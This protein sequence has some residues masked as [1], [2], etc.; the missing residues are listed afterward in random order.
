M[1]IGKGQK[2]GSGWITCEEVE[3]A[4]KK[5]LG[6]GGELRAADESKPQKATA[7]DT[8]NVVSVADSMPVGQSEGADARR[9][10]LDD[11]RERTRR[12]ARRLAGK[13]LVTLFQNGREIPPSGAAGVMEIR[14][15]SAGGMASRE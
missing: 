6:S 5:E 7:E 4:V 15:N 9:P 1:R 3:E 11:L 13:E 14:V 8:V 2:G 12:A 10:K